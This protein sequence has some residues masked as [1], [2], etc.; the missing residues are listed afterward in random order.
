MVE[1]AV[2][3]NAFFGAAPADTRALY[4]DLMKRALLNWIYAE[5]EPELSTSGVFDFTR[6]AE[7]RYWPRYAH[8]MIGLRRLENIQECVETIL[9]AGVPGDLLEAGVWRG[10]A[11][12]FMRAILKAYGIT[13][14]KVWVADSFEGLPPPNPEKYPHDA[15][16]FLNQH[17]ELAVSLEQVQANF[18]R[19]GLLDDSVRFIKGWFRD[20]LASAPVE[21]IAVL[22]MDGDLYESTTDTL[23]ALYPK[24][25]RGGFIIVDDYVA[26]P[27][28]HHAVD[29]YRSA[30]GI[31]DPIVEI[32]WTGVYWRKSI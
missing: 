22:R 2:M 20:T 9:R 28:A 23:K 8:T 14:R 21:R 31:R 29:D 11:S 24:V 19:Y 4:L 18:D 1:I 16:L 6:Q 3:A 10:G 32:D 30:H 17:R 13:N 26:V 7:G 5:A 12:I 15:G 25:A 27:A